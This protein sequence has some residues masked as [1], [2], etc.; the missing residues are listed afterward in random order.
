MEAFLEMIGGRLAG[1]QSSFSAEFTGFPMWPASRVLDADSSDGPADLSG[2]CVGQ[3][4][5]GDVM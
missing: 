3:W 1:T 2:P 4:R 5:L